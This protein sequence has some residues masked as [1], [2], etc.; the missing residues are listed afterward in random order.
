MMYLLLFISAYGDEVVCLFAGCREYTL[1][2]ECSDM[3]FSG[4]MDDLCGREDDADMRDIRGVGVS[5]SMVEEYEVACL[6]LVER[7]DGLSLRYLLSC[8]AQQVNTE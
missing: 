1:F 7:V 8:I 5:V 2:S 3:H 6:C 4:S